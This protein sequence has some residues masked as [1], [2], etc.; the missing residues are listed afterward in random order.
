MLR[1]FSLTTPLSNRLWQDAK[2]SLGFKI[3]LLLIGNLLLILSAHIC[4]PLQPVPVTMQ[5]LAVLFIG[6]SYGWRLGGLTVSAYLIEGLSGLPVFVSF[7]TGLAAL[8]GPPGGYLIAF[9]PAAIVTGWLIERGYGR[10][11]IS[12]W[13]VGLI[14]T[15]IIY[16]GGVSMLSHFIGFNQ[17]I[18]VGIKPFLL[19]DMIKISL[20][21]AIVPVFWRVPTK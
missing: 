11:F 17:A 2:S 4:I 12:S 18:A 7:P 10:N 1:T 9:L 19:I 16:T 14:G 6:M 20:L 5:S 21:A 15:L 3:G 8:L 13:L